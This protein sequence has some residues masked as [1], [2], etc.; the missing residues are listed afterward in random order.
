MAKKGTRA[1]LA[2]N[3]A[4]LMRAHGWDQT[5]L[6]KRSGVSQKT[7]SNLINPQTGISPKLDV[8]ESVA[9]AFSL[10]AWNLINRDIS[11]EIFKNGR[12]SH[13][14]DLYAHMTKESQEIVLRIAEHEASYIKKP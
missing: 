7:I 4:F 2:A 5:E 14:V 11:A 10:E 8:V 1:A 6:A 3:I 12:L 9:Q 13:L